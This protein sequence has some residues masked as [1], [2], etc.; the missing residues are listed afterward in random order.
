MN[1][2]LIDIKSNQR[3][4]PQYDPIKEGENFRYDIGK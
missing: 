1:D 2:N 4:Y 3:C